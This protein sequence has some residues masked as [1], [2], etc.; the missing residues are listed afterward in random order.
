MTLR[1]LLAAAAF[2]S[3][4]S[5]CTLT[6]AACGPD[7]C[8]GCCDANGICQ[9]GTTAAVCGAT[10]NTCAAC[11]ANEACNAGACAAVQPVDGDGGTP[12]AGAPDAGGTT[13]STP[14]T[15]EDQVLLDLGLKSTVNPDA[16]TNVADG[17]GWISTINATGGGPSP[18]KSFVYATFTANGLEK[19][20]F[21][22]ELALSNVLWDIAFRRFII[23][24][25]GGDSGPSC[26]GA[27]IAGSASFDSV[28]ANTSTGVSE[29]DGFFDDSCTFADDGSGLPTSPK[30]ALSGFYAYQQCVRMS[31]A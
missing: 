20:S 24:L 1:T 19:A 29:L 17:A 25:N 15:C 12:D 14:V 2:A 10:G 18:T 30:T 28:T 16:I 21:S 11:G 8:N 22:D 4:A 3:L 7:T 6:G 31:G 23:R 5:S 9:P 27:A 26:V 13:C